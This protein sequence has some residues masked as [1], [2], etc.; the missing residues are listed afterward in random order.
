[1]RFAY[2]PGCSL[3]G[4]A[5]EYDRSARAVA[6]ALGIELEEIP[7][8][9]CCGATSAHSTDKLL[10]L[11]LPA[12]S[13]VKADE[14]GLD[15]AAPCAACFNRLRTTVHS[16]R[17]DPTIRQELEAALGQTYAA[18]AQVY[19]LLDVIVNHY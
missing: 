10:S 14:M 13:L 12:R 18:R 11:A 6:Q 17:H 5:V 19:S 1:M 8:W 15:V 2:Y 16:V 9:S 3:S 4:T 7:D